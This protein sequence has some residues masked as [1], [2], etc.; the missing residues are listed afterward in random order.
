MTRPMQTAAALALGLYALAWFLGFTNFLEVKPFPTWALEDYG[1]YAAAFARLMAGGDPYEVR[2]I[3]EAYL[4]PPQALLGVAIFEAI[5]Q[6]G[7][8]VAAYWL[9]SAILLI[10]MALAAERYA[11]GK[12]HPFW[13]M[14]LA[15][16]LPFW[17]STYI[18]QINIFVAACIFFY[19]TNLKTRPVLAGSLLAVAVALKVT[20]L[21]LVVLAVRADFWRVVLGGFVTSVALMGLT[22]AL[23][24]TGLFW[25]F[26]EVLRDLSDQTV[27]GARQVSILNVIYLIF[28]SLGLETD[29]V[30][31][32][33]IF[34]WLAVF[35][36]MG[37][38]VWLSPKHDLRLA[39][40]VACLTMTIGANVIWLHH[41]TFLLPVLLLLAAHMPNRLALTGTLLVVAAV[42]TIPS[43]APDNFGG[44]ML[45]SALWGAVVLLLAAL[46][47][48]RRDAASLS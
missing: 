17:V 30:P 37:L 34:V 19:F 6:Q 47:Q 9:V 28:T 42:Q 15:L 29:G 7:V 2:T 14:A 1:Y 3:G 40:A 21:L 43:F 46:L 39:F 12:I 18:G 5:P 10:W 41:F 32:L 23:F 31:S 25:T 24:G 38:A 48:Q 26:F 13:L 35:A 16:F 11:G 20:P 36:A 4:Y 22:A 27:Y 8:K 33:Q 45:Q 44:L